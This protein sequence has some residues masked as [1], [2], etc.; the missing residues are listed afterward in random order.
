MN[1][2]ADNKKENKTQ[3]VANSLPKQQSSGESTFKFVDN[4][5]E[6]IAQRKLQ[7]AINNSPRVQ[8]LKAYQE[9]ANNS[10]LVKQLRAYQAMAN[11][12]TS[13]SAQRKENL[14]EKTLQGKF[15][16]IQKKE[17]NTGLPDNLKSGVENLSGYSMDDVKVHYNSDK[18]TQLQAHAYAQGSD[19]HLASGQEKYLP[20]EAWHVVQQ[21]QGRVEP[22]MQMKGGFNVNDDVG[23]EK[24]ADIMGAQALQS[25]ELPQKVVTQKKVPDS[26]NGNVQTKQLS[27]AIIQLGVGASKVSPVGRIEAAKFTAEYSKPKLG[28]LIHQT[29]S[30]FAKIFGDTAAGGIGQH[31]KERAKDLDKDVTKFRIIKFAITE[32]KWWN[33]QKGLP[34]IVGSSMSKQMRAY[35]LITKARSLGL[36]PPDK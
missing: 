27:K 8:Q 10:P 2:Y 9:M 34:G 15:E 5:P 13:K 14:E 18:P 17:N 22:T 31:Y 26:V 25:V 12:F 36:L 3:A 6:A 1:T 16:P 19:I 11:N 33:E 28:Y 32:T 7:E 21:K 23:L 4:R 29:V 30:P 35:L 24:E 20:H